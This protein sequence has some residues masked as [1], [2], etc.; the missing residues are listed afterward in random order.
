M[1]QGIIKSVKNSVKH[2]YIP[3]IV[4]LMFIVVGVWT[5]FNPVGSFLGL[6]IVFTISF[7]ISGMFEITFALA[8]KDELEHWGWELANGILSLVIGLIMLFNPAISLVTLPFYIGFVILFR[9]IMAISSSLELKK[10]GV[11]DWGNLM[12]LGVLGTI[13]AFILLWNPEFAGLTIVIWV[14]MAFLTVG[15]FAIYSSIK[16]K[17]LK[18]VGED[19]KDEIKEELSI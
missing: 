4:G 7:L 8:N 13:F 18:N 19:L 5:L 1:A 17:K 12:A 6:A 9:S 15:A 10:Y 2:W 3:L 14:A 11:I 16:L